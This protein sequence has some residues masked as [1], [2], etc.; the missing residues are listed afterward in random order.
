[1]KDFTDAVTTETGMGCDDMAASIKGL[2]VY[3]IDTY[4]GELLRKAMQAVIAMTELHA[5]L[6]DAR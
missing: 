3:A 4:R 5:E 6:Y 1:M 2:A